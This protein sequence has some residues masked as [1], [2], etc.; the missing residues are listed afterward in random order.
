MMFDILTYLPAKKKRS[1]SGWWSFNAPCCH[2][3]GERPD[4]RQRGGVLVNGDSWTYHCFNCSYKATYKKG[5][6]LSFKTRKLLL[7]LGVDEPTIDMLQLEAIRQRTLGGLLQEEEVVPQKEVRFPSIDLPDGL[8]RVEEHDEFSEFLT[9]R[10]IDPCCYPFLKEP[11]AI[12]RNKNRIVIPF[13]YRGELVGYSA[14]FLDD[15][16]PKYLHTIPHGYVFGTDL[17]KPEWDHVIVC[18]G[19]FD[20][21]AIN[22]LAV[23]HNDITPDQIRLISG[24]AKKVIVVPDLDRA[25]MSLVDRALQHGWSVSMPQWDH[26]V[27]DISDAVKLYGKLATLIT[28]MSSTETNQLKI[29]LKRKNYV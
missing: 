16:R 7:W 28:I 8:V 1:P 23:L 22:G 24:L 17:Q 12:G 11:G 6:R 29:K 27:K 10:G 15:R 26:G 5:E 9:N 2:H 13:T 18:E 20:A 25:G 4:T 19:V 3:N 14:R 21:L